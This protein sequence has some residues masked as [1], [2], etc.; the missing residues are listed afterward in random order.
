MLES[1]HIMSLSIA[2]LTELRDTAK[3]AYLIALKGKNYG[4]STA[5]TTRSFTRQEI[6]KLR[7]DFEYWDRRI[8]EL[9]SGTGMKMRYGLP[10][11]A[12]ERRRRND[13]P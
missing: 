8:D 13:L 2:D 11:E 12:R 6:D 9:N 5:G 1:W 3:V 10:L 7:A 4:L